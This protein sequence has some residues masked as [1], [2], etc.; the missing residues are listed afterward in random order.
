MN[1]CGYTTAIC[2]IGSSVCQYASNGQYYSCGMLD[3]Q[4]I[5]ALSSEDP[6]KGLVVKYGGGDQCSGGPMRAT[7]IN[8][9][10][11]ED[12]PGYIYSAEE[13]DCDYTLSMYSKVACGK[14]VKYGSGGGIGAGSII[15][16]M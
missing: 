1:F 8:I 9:V 16:I 5:Y 12:A 3:S 15:L 14:S 6:G 11:A 13:G 10:C 7:T 2:T 4:T